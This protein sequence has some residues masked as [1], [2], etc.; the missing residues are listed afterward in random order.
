MDLKLPGE[1]DL[2]VNPS[3]DHFTVFTYGQINLE[4]SLKIDRMPQL[5][6]NMNMVM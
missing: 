3:Q 5:Y 4:V 1:A 2:Y 6:Q